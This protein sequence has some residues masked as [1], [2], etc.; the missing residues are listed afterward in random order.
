M[1]GDQF[2]ASGKADEAECNMPCPG[3]SKENCGGELR[4]NIYETGLGERMSHLE[5]L[6]QRF[7]QLVC[8]TTVINYKS[9]CG[10]ALR[11]K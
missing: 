2:G 9:L 5:L 3:N 6:D 1:C 7:L 10:T 8:I 11:I 4:N